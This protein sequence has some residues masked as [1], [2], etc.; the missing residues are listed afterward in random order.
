MIFPRERRDEAKLLTKD[1][2][3]RTAANFAKLPELPGAATAAIAT[4]IECNTNPL[5]SS[6]CHVAPPLNLI[7]F[8][9]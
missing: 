5:S 1:E 8:N 4:L 9:H 6:P 7:A 3:R 2:A